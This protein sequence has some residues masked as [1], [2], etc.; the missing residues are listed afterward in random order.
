MYKFLDVTKL[1]YFPTD[2]FFSH[3]NSFHGA[4]GRGH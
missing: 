3:G 2:S 1:H 4:G